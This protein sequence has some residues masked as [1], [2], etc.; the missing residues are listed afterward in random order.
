MTRPVT[1]SS[2]SCVCGK[3]TQVEQTSVSGIVDEAAWVGWILSPHKTARLCAGTALMKMAKHEVDCRQLE[4]AAS[5][6]AEQGS[7]QLAIAKY[8]AA[9]QDCPTSS[10]LYEQLAQCLM[11]TEQYTEAYSAAAQAVSYSPQVQSR[12]LVTIAKILL[13]QADQT[14]TA[15]ARCNADL[16]QVRAE[17]RTGLRGST[18]L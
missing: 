2:G 17:L 18:L 7:F 16:C 10:R 6:L 1:S 5:K 3:R 9:I 14:V 15:V 12:C 4:Q 8:S 11:E 13:H